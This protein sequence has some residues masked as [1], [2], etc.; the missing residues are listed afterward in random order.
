MKY[1][2][3][4]YLREDGT[5]YYIGKGTGRRAYEPYGHRIPVPTD[6]SRI[7][8][9]ERQ[10]TE[11]GAYAIER[12]M[13]QWYGRKYDG[14]G[15]LRN[16]CDGGEGGP[17]YTGPANGMYG[18]TRSEELKAH[19]S[20]INKGKKLSA[21]TIAKRV[22]TLK[23]NHTEERRAARSARYSGTGNNMYGRKRSAEHTQ[24]IRE[25]CSKAI[26]CHQTDT[27]YPSVSEAARVLGLKQG[28]ISNVLSPNNR[29]QSTKGYTFE[30]YI[31]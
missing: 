26:Y 12:R 25:L 24:M 20:A 21:E 22:A 29:Q 10:L 8:F 27:V 9:L 14:T 19:L 2:V 6:R 16:I 11:V 18:K 4:A 31:Q 15:I 23:R 5:P 30:Y 28:D 3:Y 13:I 7:V 1:Y 17:G